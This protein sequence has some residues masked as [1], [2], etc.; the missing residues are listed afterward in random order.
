M[1][2]KKR[3]DSG[4]LRACV[5]ENVETTTQVDEMMQKQLQENQENR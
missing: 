5:G 2:V 4:G 1:T 3:K